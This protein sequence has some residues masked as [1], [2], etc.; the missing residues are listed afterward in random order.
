M[1]ARGEHLK[2]VLFP[3][4]FDFVFLRHSY[5]FIGGLAVIGV[6]LMIIGFRIIV[7]AHCTLH[8]ASAFRLPC[9]A[10][11]VQSQVIEQGRTIS[12]ALCA[13]AAARGYPAAA[14][15]AAADQRA[16]DDHPADPA[17]GD[18]LVA[19]LGQYPPAQRP[20]GLLHVPLSHRRRRRHQLRLLRQGVHLTLTLSHCALLLLS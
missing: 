5:Y 8:I 14:A 11:I 2:S 16:R 15:S 4:Q 13:V 6:V 18:G 20:Q 17:D 7:R 12:Q 3:K 9:I 19:P 10:P 1:T